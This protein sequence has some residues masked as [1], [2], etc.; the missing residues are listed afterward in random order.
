MPNSTPIGAT[1]SAA[2]GSA[3][4]CQH[5][6][7]TPDSRRCLHY[8]EGGHCLQ[9]A[10]KQGRCIE[11]LKVNA[12]NSTT[13]STDQRFQPSQTAQTLAP[14]VDRDL[15]GNPVQANE[16]PRTTSSKR[17]RSQPEPQ[18]PTPPPSG[19]PPLVRNVTDEEIASFKA[20]GAEVS[21]RSE[22]LGDV[23]LV[24]K[25]TDLDRLEISIEH[26]ITLTA[27]CA[28]FPGAKVVAIK[29]AG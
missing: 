4:T 20:L 29:R 12:P 6:H 17:Q 23:H 10:A 15:F 13:A 21:I 1:S 27:I 25:Y 2:S 7:R 18:A 9:P 16:R 22:A 26:S 24:P 5:Y 28:A 8:Q 14:T 19:K 11:W 3:I